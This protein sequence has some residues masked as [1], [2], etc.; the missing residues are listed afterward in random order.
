MRDLIFKNLVSDDRKKRI[1][2]AQEI[3]S[4]DGVRTEIYR[5]F[6]CLIKPAEE[7]KDQTEQPQVY[8]TKYHDT[9]LQTEKL[10]LKIK[11]GLYAINNGELYFLSFC[12]SLRVNIRQ[13][14]PS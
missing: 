10:L 13:E 4:N 7:T 8:I 6:V 11:G 3:I 5:G 9:K 12:H 2:Q 1:L 14:V